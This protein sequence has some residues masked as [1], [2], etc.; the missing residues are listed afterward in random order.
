MALLGAAM[1]RP[2]A[3]RAGGEE[4]ILVYNTAVPDS[5][6]VADHYA[7]V[8]QVPAAQIFGFNLTTN[9]VMTR[10]DFQKQL[11]K[12]LVDKLE[13]A[14]L[15]KFAKVTVPDGSEKAFHKE[16]RVV[17]SK[18]R[19]AVLCYGV[20][21]KIAPDSLLEKALAKLTRDEFRHN[22]AAVDSELACLPLI[23]TEISF[24]GFV[25]NP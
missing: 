13:S 10:E 19:Y 20:P 9:E 2:T 6:A 25:T 14:G 22:E 3:A 8:R 18:I 4:V 23:R 1:L 11:Q 24:T 5:R 15:W 21:L 7:A 16:V 12:P 17:D